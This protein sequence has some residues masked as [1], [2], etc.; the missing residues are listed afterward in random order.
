MWV[1][2]DSLGTSASS[3]C[4]P[5][6]KPCSVGMVVHGDALRRWMVRACGWRPALGRRSCARLVGAHPPQST[7]LLPPF[8]HQ[9]PLWTGKAGEMLLEALSSHQQFK[10]S[11]ITPVDGRCSSPTYISMC[12]CVSM[13]KAISRSWSW[14]LFAG[15]GNKASLISESG[16][17]QTSVRPHHLNDLTL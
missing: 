11:E 17:V 7:C 10:A 4:R 1:G 13:E 14:L 8:S 16:T 15:N 6:F 9:F 5:F 12:L 3:F 2:Q